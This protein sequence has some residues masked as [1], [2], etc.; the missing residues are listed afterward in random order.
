MIPYNVALQQRTILVCILHL[1]NSNLLQQHDLDTQLLHSYYFSAH[2]KFTTT[3]KIQ[4]VP[5][6]SGPN[7][8][9]YPSHF[10]IGP[11]GSWKQNPAGW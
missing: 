4:G 5:P 2:P 8:V 1:I 3:T 7:I 11:D 6:T 9:R 10:I